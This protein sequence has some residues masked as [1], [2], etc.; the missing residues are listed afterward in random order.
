MIGLTS[1][2]CQLLK[3]LCSKDAYLTTEEITRHL[4]VSARTVR[5]ELNVIDAFVRE[6]GSASDAGIQVLADSFV[7]EALFEFERLFLASI[8]LAQRTAR[9]AVG[10]LLGNVGLNKVKNRLMQSSYS[11]MRSQFSQDRFREYILRFCSDSRWKV[12]PARTR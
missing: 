8:V 9:V 3:I 1:R 4:D 12:R 5:T 7:D 6:Y 11:K 2:Q 10:P